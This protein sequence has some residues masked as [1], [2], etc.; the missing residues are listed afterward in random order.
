MQVFI[1]QGRIRSESSIET[2]DGQDP[3]HLLQQPSTQ[4]AL[5]EELEALV[6]SLTSSGK[7]TKITPELQSLFESIQDLLY[8][9]DAAI[10][11]YKHS[12]VY[13]SI[14][15]LLQKRIYGEKNDNLTCK[16]A[17][18][19]V[20]VD[21]LEYILFRGYT[22]Y[23]DLNI[24][25]KNCKELCSIFLSKSDIDIA[26]ICWLKYSALKLSFKSDEIID[27]LST[28]PANTKMGAIVIWL[29]NFVPYIVE[30]NPFNIDLFVRWATERIFILEQSSYWPKVGLR[31]IDEIIHVLA[32]SLKIICLRPLSMDDLDVLKDRINYITELKEKYKINLLLCEL[33]S[34]S[35]S[36]VAL[37]MLRRC[38][39]EDLEAFLQEYLP[40]Y[41]TR[42]LLDTDDIL[43]TFIENETASGGG[44]VDGSRLELLLTAFHTPSNRLECLL[45]VLK[46]LDVPWNTSVNKIAVN[47]A[48]NATRDF[49]AA[50]PDLFLAQEIQK[51]LNYANVKVV[52][53]KY[54]FPLTYTDYTVVLHR[55]VSCTIV[56]LNDLKAVTT[57][58]S[59]YANYGNSLYINKCLENCDSRSALEY[60]QN[61]PL[62]EKKILLKTIMVKYE[63]IINGNTYSRNI[64]RNYLDFLKGTYMLN[65]IQINDIE[66]LY[67][68][69]NVY[70]IQLNMDDIHKEEQY[71]KMIIA[72]KENIKDDGTL[73]GS[74]GNIDRLIRI[75]KTENTSVSS[76]LSTTS[77]THRVRDFIENII[78]LQSQNKSIQNG[79]MLSVLQDC[80]NLSLLTDSFN[81]L[82][83]IV[84][85]CKEENVHDIISCLSVLNTIINTNVI[86][87][88]LTMTWKFNY[89]FLPISSGTAINDFINYMSSNKTPNN[90]EE[91]LN[92][93]QGKCDFIPLR[94]ISNAISYSK[95]DNFPWQMLL[96]IKDTV[97]KKI[98]FKVIA[99]QELDEILT[100]T[101]LLIEKST[102]HNF[103][104]SDTL[105]G[106]NETLS[107]TLISY[108]TH[109]TI[110]RTFTFDSN[111]QGS[112]VYPPKYI[113]KTKFN[114][115]LSDISLP[116]NTEQTWDVKVILFYIL[117][118]YPD[119]SCDRLM[120]LGKALNV[121]VDD[122]LS[123]Q[124][125]SI[126][127]TWDLKYKIYRDELGCRQIYMEKES[128]LI[129]K[130]VVIWE[131]VT[132]K[133]FLIDV[134]KDFWRNGEVT[135]HGRTVS[136]N[137][138]YFEVFICI[139]Q[140]LFDAASDSSNKK[141]FYLLNFLR[142]YRRISSPKQYEFELFS[143][144]GMFP[145]IGYYRLPFHLF[146]REDMW[147]NLKSEITL[148]TYERW[149]PVVSLLALDSDPQIAKDM[150]CSNALKQ[151]MTSRKRDD[152]DAK[153]SEPWRLISRE[154]PLLRAAH[155]CVKHIANMEWA[156]ACLFYVLQGCTRGADQVAAAQLCYQ[157]AQ[158]WAALQPG[159]KAVKQM[160]RLHSTLSTRHALYKI[161]WACEELVRL[162]IEPVQLVKALYLHPDFGNKIA[163]YD[164]NRAANEI[165]DKNNINISSIRIQILENLLDKT[166][167]NNKDK[168]MALNSR[169]LIVAKYILKATCPKMGAIYLSRIAFDDESD[170]NNCKKMR[171]LQCLMSVVEP[172]TAIKVTNKERDALWALLLELLGAVKLEC[173]DMPWVIAT[174]MQDKKRA[175][176]QLL[177]TVS[178]NAEGLKIT[179][180][181]VNQFGN[182][183][184]IRDL[185]PQLLRSNLYDEIIPLLVKIYTPPDSLIYTAWRAV[186]LS[187]FQSA[188]YPITERQ[189]SKCIN[190]L[191]LLPI[192]PVIKDDDLKEIWKNCIRLKSF[193]LGCLVLPY[194]T[195]QARQTLPELQKID[196]RNLIASIKNLHAET[197]LVSGAMHVIENMA[198]KLYKH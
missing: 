76:L 71:L 142:E 138:Y 194:M 10:K 79:K 89:V 25:E 158:R 156:G 133:N 122:A 43:R 56:D 99:A 20:K 83:E 87:K 135:L 155:R 144:K 189:K 181:L 139:H 48:A 123:L 179:A 110:R 162:S 196:R 95:F 131:N 30:Q 16:I 9:I 153:E 195:T 120:E 7:S 35:P 171:A 34:Q 23:R 129:Q 5:Q 69:K 121:D 32:S 112:V 68:L 152:A 147:S 182:A 116:E 77:A 108:L 125:I 57:V 50:D 33:S 84:C 31:F 107:P 85:K 137:P 163:R 151:T 109:P 97:C 180:N 94:M 55:L 165:A 53:K 1:C 128:N 167:D 75:N 111:W 146:M 70:G 143:V 3:S 130:C 159:N 58:M 65:H 103:S 91:C 8:L 124:L 61:M 170:F 96:K 18:V 192:C 164:V 102:V 80:N 14:F 60:F 191:N 78:N 15:Y 63:Q 93:V 114:I 161:E 6:E 39:T 52:L 127:S 17:E 92:D 21:L 64:E 74:G 117:R 193:G 186:I 88:N 51:E 98:L 187:P 29:K 38:Y 166:N 72:W 149:L 148:E 168:K 81:L 19:I 12:T 24:F 178:C 44:T 177:Q 173:I 49:T 2:C 106:Q 67:H 183:Q 54:N 132:R 28:I 145:E 154:E 45:H 134:L 188:D 37:I 105:K 184:M 113:L 118:Q 150:I 172:D 190:A 198:S 100:T 11:L 157:F 82:I 174:F 46:A 197:Y 136:I 26:S 175:L 141:E 101:L 13:K 42:Y 90:L 22:S 140:L 73:T 4:E 86:V 126:L 59:A 62:K 119:I 40:N 169:E 160:E 41:A 115:N 66:N 176:E 27:V 47:A 104:V 185:I 36:E